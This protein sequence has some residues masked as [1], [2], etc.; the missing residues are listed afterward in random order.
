MED[1]CGMGRNPNNRVQPVCGEG[2]DAGLPT[3]P[4]PPTVTYTSSDDEDEEDEVPTSVSRTLESKMV[5][6]IQVQ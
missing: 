2:Q 5:A 4:R 3:S 6:P 1:I